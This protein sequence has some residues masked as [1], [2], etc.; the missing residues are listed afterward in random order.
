VRRLILIV[1]FGFFWTPALFGQ[2]PAKLN[3]KI[4][5]VLE[6]HADNEVAK[7]S[8]EELSTNYSDYL[9][10]DTRSKA[11]FEVSHLPKAIW[12]GSTFQK[13]DLDSLSLGKPVVVYCSI[14]V[15]SS[16]YAN[17][18]QKAIENPVY[19]LMGSI[20]H[21]KDSGNQVVNRHGKSTDSIHVFSKKWGEY[22]KSGV[23][24]Y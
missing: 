15:R 11:E 20:F 9:I 17:K 12:V 19:N 22:L 8:V 14:G 16:K 1:I 2:Q 18:L 13:S 10:L 24:V 23:K 5:E 4:K 21:W 6:K 7:I 3:P